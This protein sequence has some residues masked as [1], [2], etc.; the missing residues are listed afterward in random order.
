MKILKYLLLSLFCCSA[1]FA[2]ESAEGEALVAFRA[3]EGVEVTEASVA[4]GD[5]R[6][7]IDGIAASVQAEVITT[8]G[9]LSASTGGKILALVRSDTKTT[10]ELIR[11][12]KAHPDVLSASPNHKVRIMP[13]K[14]KMHHHIMNTHTGG[15]VQ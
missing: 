7:Y 12:L 14:K 2:S 4:S 3:P 9:T 1:A 13:V 8:Y 15:T 6:A 11:D 10:K 5:V